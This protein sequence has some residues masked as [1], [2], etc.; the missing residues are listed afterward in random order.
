[1]KSS[2]RVMAERRVRDAIALKNPVRLL[3][4]TPTELMALERALDLHGR[5]KGISAALASSVN[6]DESTKMDMEMTKI[7]Q[8]LL[9]AMEA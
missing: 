8:D 3:A 2:W 4:D 6:S 1:M 9:R 7:E 5:P